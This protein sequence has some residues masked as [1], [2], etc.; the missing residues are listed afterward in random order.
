MN[1]IETEKINLIIE[2][3]G[4]GKLLEKLNFNEDT[5]SFLRRINN[6]YES[7]I[8]NRTNQLEDIEFNKKIDS[9]IKKECDYCYKLSRDII[10]IIRNMSNG[11]YYEPNIEEFNNDMTYVKFIL[12]KDDYIPIL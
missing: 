8:K 1:N 9:I 7:F 2:N 4:S 5:M 11:V 12:N 10:V 6:E 3:K